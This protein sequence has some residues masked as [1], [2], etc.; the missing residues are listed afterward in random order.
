MQRS[1]SKTHLIFHIYGLPPAINECALSS[2][3]VPAEVW[4]LSWRAM[5]SDIVI[6]AEAHGK[7]VNRTTDWLVLTTGEARSCWAIWS[8]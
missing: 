2:T 3:T 1:N 4:R 7:S 5:K 8:G 6:F